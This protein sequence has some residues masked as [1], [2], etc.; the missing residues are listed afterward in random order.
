MKLSEMKT[1]DLISI[2]KK[3]YR[4]PEDEF[5]ADTR[6]ILR[7]LILVR[8]QIS[9]IPDEI[10]RDVLI[11]MLPIFSNGDE[12]ISAVYHG[13]AS[14]AIV[15]DLLETSKEDCPGWISLIGDDELLLIFSC[16]ASDN[17]PRAAA[18]MRKL[19]FEIC[20]RSLFQKVPDDAIYIFVRR[21]VPPIN[22]G[23]FRSVAENMLRL[24]FTCMYM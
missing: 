6:S 21:Q 9:E 15:L 13:L 22:S 14:E 10:L 7:E 20:Q 17:H 8:D 16:M 3:A 5:V 2:L 4:R 23:H 12:S 24:I 18:L 1:E 11:D 19:Y